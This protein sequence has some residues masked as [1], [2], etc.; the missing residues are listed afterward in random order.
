MSVEAKFEDCLASVV[1]P[2]F[3]SEST[4]EEAVLSVLSQ[5]FP[6]ELLICDDASTD[7][8][9]AIV[10]EFAERDRRIKVWASSENGGAAAAR[11]RCL[12]FATGR[13]VA[14]LDADD[15][16]KPKVLSSH[17]AAHRRM[18][19]GLT[20]GRYDVI[21]SRGNARGSFEPPESV[22]LNSLLSTCDIGLLTACV[23]RGI[24]GDFRFPC[25]PK[26]DYA[27]WI[28]FCRRLNLRPQRAIGVEAVYRTSGDSVSA[29]KVA[30]AFKQWRVIREVGGCGAVEAVGHL[31]R[32]AAHGMKKH[33]IY[34]SHN[35]T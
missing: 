27:L 31:L 3:N 25:M 19:C 21:D 33:L 18:R 6:L 34:Y 28:D 5:D 14:F 10:R 11:N 16:W 12:E 24:T 4:I 1:M 15:L 2:A 32:Y 35:K 23:D 8:T 20:Y 26:E 7:N 17:V 29:N 30:E 13:Y 22:D 9:H